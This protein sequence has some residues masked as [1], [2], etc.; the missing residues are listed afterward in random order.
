MTQVIF[1]Q[2]KP[3][4]VIMLGVLL[5]LLSIISTSSL[6]DFIFLFLIALLLLGYRVSYRISKDYNNKKIISLFWI[7]LIIMKLDIIYPD[8]ISVFGAN[9]SKRNDWGPVSAIGTNSNAD[10]FVVR[11]FKESEKFTLFKT[12]KYEEARYLA[13]QLSGVLEVELVDKIDN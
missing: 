3:T 5:V 6:V 7:P 4:T 2:D 9:F 11:L 13:R 1:K 12:G 8:Y 10:K